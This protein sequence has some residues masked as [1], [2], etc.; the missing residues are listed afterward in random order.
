MEHSI[1]DQI[2][3]E[4]KAFFKGYPK[5][6]YSKNNNLVLDGIPVFVYHTIDPEL[7][8][9]HL[10]YLDD[11]GYKTLTIHEF[12]ELITE[13]KSNEDKKLVLLTIDDARSSVWRFAYPLLAKYKMHATVFIIPGITETTDS[14]RFN[15]NDYWNSNCSVEDIYKIDPIDNF[16][17]TWN[18]IK[19]MYNSGFVNIESH[20]LFHKEVFINTNIVEFI[21]TDTPF[22]K[23]NF[24]GSPYYKLNNIQKQLVLSDFVGLPVFETVPLMLGGSR[25]EV[26]KEFLTTCKDIFNRAKKNRDINWKR[27][28]SDFVKK[29]A[30]N[31]KFI[32]YL[33]NSVKDVYEDLKLAREKIQKHLDN[34]AGNH[35]C[36]PWTRGSDKTVE[37]CKELGIKS[38]FWGVLDGKK[39]NKS[40][41]DPYFISRIKNDFIFRLPGR[42]RASLISIYKHKIKR[43][44]S[45]EKVF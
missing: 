30:N 34:D 17:C 43:R 35:L 23:Y 20:T 32:F 29:E 28:I 33:E 22:L 10:K 4:I 6:V 25:I 12:Y 8:E 40:G 44:L 39:I 2:S 31:K 11:N 19:E 36:L 15:L 41:D 13:N 7:F 5:F 9:A 37:I 42:G 26:T 14:C 21:E 18:E 24:K 3:I 38:C 1:K 45:G 27:K 16:L